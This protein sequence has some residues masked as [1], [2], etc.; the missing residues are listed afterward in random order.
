MSIYKQTLESKIEFYNNEKLVNDPHTVSG[1]N[2]VW[3]FTSHDSIPEVLQGFIQRYFGQYRIR[4]IPIESINEIMNDIW[5]GPGSLEKVF[6]LEED[7][8]ASGK[9]VKFTAADIAS[10]KAKRQDDE[11]DDIVADKGL[12]DIGFG[13][14]NE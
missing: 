14:L 4:R 13:D 10:I 5:E 11:D 12:L 3:Q 2:G 8:R 9:D 7:M 6:R 1:F